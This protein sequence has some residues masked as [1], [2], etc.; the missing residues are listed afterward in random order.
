[1]IKKVI[2]FF[3]PDVIEVTLREKALSAFLA[4]IATLACMQISNV[5]IDI[6]QMPIYVASIG[7]SA[8]LV[9]VAPKSPLSQPWPILASHF[10]SASIGVLCYIVFTDLILASSMAVGLSIFFMYLFKCLHPPG[11]AASLGVVLAGSEVHN[12]GFQFV[13]TP[14][15]LNAALLIVFGLILNNLVPGRRYPNV[16]MKRRDEDAAKQLDWS[17]N[18]SLF[19]EADLEAALTTMGTYVDVSRNDLTRIYRLAVT[20]AN[21]REIGAVTCS[22]V[23]SKNTITA[24]YSTELK[25]AWLVMQEN[26][27]KALP[28][29]DRFNRVIG[30]VTLADFFRNIDVESADGTLQEKMRLFLKRT[31]GSEANKVEVVGQIMSSPAIT[32]N[33]ETHVIQVLSIFTDQNI[34]HLPVINHKKYLVGIVTRTD[35]MRVL[36]VLR[37]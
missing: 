23:M 15:L 22:D 35:I 12:L 24:E 34:H 2:R 26:Q 9:F 28:I 16:I 30:V 14:V 1:M 37:A 21:Q 31:E 32:V 19:N 10:V 36:S 29:V 4:F 33:E 5:I 25:V 6:N 3:T 20:H 8:L 17:W 18:K 27:L 13:F 7:A 11:G